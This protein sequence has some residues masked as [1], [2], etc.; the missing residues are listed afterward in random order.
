[1]EHFYCSSCDCEFSKDIHDL[2]FCGEYFFKRYKAYNVTDIIK[3]YGYDVL[4]AFKLAKEKSDKWMTFCSL[5]CANKMVKKMLHQ[6][7]N[8]GAQCGDLLTRRYIDSETLEM[9]IPKS[10]QCLHDGIDWV[11]YYRKESYM[12]M[13]FCSDQCAT[14][15]VYPVRKVE[16]PQCHA[17]YSWNALI[18]YLDQFGQPKTNDTHTQSRYILFCGEECA[19]KSIHQDDR[20][21]QTQNTFYDCGYIDY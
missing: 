14:T 3:E 15:F 21:K 5:K 20:T 4:T 18:Y 11:E 13:V 12:H 2:Y 9:I 16:C 10:D 1:M 6:C 8:C 7:S 19:I 17:R